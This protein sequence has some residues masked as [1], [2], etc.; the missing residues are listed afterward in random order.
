MLSRLAEPRTFSSVIPPEVSR[1]QQPLYLDALIWLLRADLV[2]QMRV[3]VRIVARAAIK[4]A[5]KEAWLSKTGATL[6]GG[7]GKRGSSIAGSEDGELEDDETEESVASTT[8]ATSG[9]LGVPGLDI[10]KVRNNSLG[11]GGMN[12]ATGTTTTAAMAM[13]SISPTTTPSM[14]SKKLSSSASPLL[15]FHNALSPRA[16]GGMMSAAMSSSGGQQHYGGS[17]TTGT[18]DSF[19]TS[20]STR[21][22]S[23]D[24]EEAEA[25]GESLDQDTVV[26]EPGQ[27]TPIQGRWLAQMTLDKDPKVVERFEKCVFFPRLSYRGSERRKVD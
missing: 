12:T 3:F 2:I 25:V 10:P 27:P 22:D 8:T 5:A 11:L 17:T 19:S 20:T 21:A 7:G 14:F 4:Q 15:P 16:R 9:P 26:G 1:S 24:Q 6:M 13:A 18:G 23:M